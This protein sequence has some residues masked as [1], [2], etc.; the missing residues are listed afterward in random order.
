MEQRFFSS[1]SLFL[2]LTL[3]LVACSPEL[4]EFTDSNLEACARDA[5]SIK[6]RDIL[7]ED[8][9]ALKHLDCPA[10][11]ITELTGLEYFVGLET[12]SVWENDI[13]NLQPLA[14]LTELTW[15]QLGFN[16]I[17]NLQPLTDLKKLERLDVSENNIQGIK[18]LSNLNKLQWLN[19]DGNRIDSV[20]PL[21][22]LSNL[23]WLTLAHNVAYDLSPLN[24]LESDGCEIY[25]EYQGS[26]HRS[27]AGLG[28]DGP[29]EMDAAAMLPISDEFLRADGV[30][31]L[32][33]LVESTPSFSYIVGDRSYP[34]VLQSTGSIRL[35]GALV[36]SQTEDGDVA[37]GS[38]AD[39]QV[40]CGESFA[41]TCSVRLGRKLPSAMD[42]ERYGSVQPVVTAA[43][44]F[45][46]GD[47]LDEAFYG[48]ADTS[49]FP[50]VLA[51]PNQFDAGSCLF[52]SSTGAVEILL[53]Q[54]VE[55]EAITYDGPTDLSERYLMNASEYVP[56]SYI[57]YT[58]TDVFYT[59]NYHGG[60]LLSLDY[61]FTAGYVDGDYSCSYNWNDD[62]PGNWES[63]LVET[64]PAERTVIYVDP[65]RNNSSIWNVGLMDDR[66]IERIKYEL[67]TKKAPVVVVYNHYLYWHADI[68][69]GYDDTI[70]TGGCPMVDSS[71][72][73]FRQQGQSGYADKIEAHM[74]DIGGCSDYGV[75]YVRDSIYDG[76]PE[77]ESYEH[78]DFSAK[79][80]E[81][82]VETSYNW[83]KFLGNHAYSV[84]RR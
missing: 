36:V 33:S 20:A 80:S 2:A 74:E 62:M 14:E 51:S 39:E 72:S 67:R 55:P 3:P 59:F 26:D 29:A 68:I 21:S 8:A 31:A 79:Y 66:H 40:L 15:L 10:Q 9:A 24:A 23:S 35:E 16:Q 57:Q 77:E 17:V 27:S 25:A 56:N 5:L 44:T 53:N 65:L 60:A 41:H 71:V 84:H 4:V 58:Y 70:S 46:N 22:G 37:I 12:L 45:A 1:F 81:R 52:M 61:P 48:A 34:M 32:D 78:Y 83:V 69:V 82:I 19:L 54:G 38:L 11:N 47:N 13:K 76:G 6:K 43:I 18:V 42:L 73:Y 28:A 50:Y 30:I 64:P 63:L 49:M 7:P 75:F